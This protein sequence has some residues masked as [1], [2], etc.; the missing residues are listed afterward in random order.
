MATRRRFI[1]SDLSQPLPDQFVRRLG[2]VFREAR[3]AAGL[4]QR[5]L[6]QVAG[7]ARTGVI[8]F[9]RGERI[10]TIFVCKALANALQRPLHR[11][12]AAAEEDAG[13]P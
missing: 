4:S 13:I 8:L 7:V 5:K 2:I 1:C 11:L 9:E 6:A 12:V 10:P 3:V